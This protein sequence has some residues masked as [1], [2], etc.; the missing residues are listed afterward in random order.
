MEDKQ[1]GP[2]MNHTTAWIIITLSLFS[3]A[4]LTQTAAQAIAASASDVSPLGQ[5]R[6]GTKPTKPDKPGTANPNDK[7]RGMPP[8]GSAGQGPVQRERT[9]EIEKRVQSG[10]V[11]QKEVSEQLEELQSGSNPL[12][13]ETPRQ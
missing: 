4:A 11:D 7:A 9:Q 3:F 5:S 13:D 10:G 6:E 2:L 1:R 12:S 8:A